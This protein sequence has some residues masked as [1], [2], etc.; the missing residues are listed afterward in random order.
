VAEGNGAAGFFFCVRANHIT[1]RSSTFCGNRIC[2]ISVGTRDC[3]NYITGCQIT[4][5]AGP[6]LLIRSTSRPV[7]VHSCHVSDCRIAGN[8]HDHGYAQVDVLGDAHDLILEHN[9]IV[10]IPGRSQSG[11]YL[12][13]STERIWLDEN[14]ISDCSPAVIGAAIRPA[15]KPSFDSGMDAVTERHYR[16]LPPLSP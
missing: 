14:V 8:A 7:E 5:N 4:D 2:G 12:A 11:V 13:P 16:H 6:G 15:I 1:V 3:H 10:G 9:E